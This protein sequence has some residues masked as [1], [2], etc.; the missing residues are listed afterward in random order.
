MLSSGAHLAGIKDAAVD[1][2]AARSQVE[3]FKY[4][5]GNSS[6]THLRSVTHP[7]IRTPNDIY[8][9]NEHEIYVTNDHYYRGG[10]M[11]QIE[12][13]GGHEFA[14]WSDVVYVHWASLDASSGTEG[15][16]AKVALRETH[17]PNGLGHG[18]NGEV[19]LGRAVAGMMAILR[20]RDDKTLEITEQVRLKTTVDNPFYFEDPYVRESGGRNASG[21]VLA[22][23]T[24]AMGFPKDESQPVSV[25][26]V[27]RTAKAEGGGRDGMLEGEGRDEKGKKGWE[28]HLIFQD[29]G[30][31]IHTASTAV[32]VAIDPRENEGRKEGWLFVAGPLA[33]NV[34]R[35]KIE[36]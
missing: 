11:R 30:R 5:I 2:P 15:V 20:P 14:G 23:L 7:L 35:T 19:V 32:L 3:L 13:F 27:Q 28:H 16:D 18:P 29:D 6:T 21:Y 12:E 22:C 36:L 17:N 4:T 10:L 31:V 25:W 34:I 33:E 9:V 24:R 8:A 1:I 26:L